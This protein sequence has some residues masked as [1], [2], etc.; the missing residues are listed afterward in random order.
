MSRNSKDSLTGLSRALRKNMTPEEKRI[1][2]GFLKHIP[3]TVNRQKTIDNFIVDF[4]C[5]ELKLVIDTPEAK[6][7]L[8]SFMEE[9][10]HVAVLVDKEIKHIDKASM[11]RLMQKHV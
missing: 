9:E 10:P 6:A 11:D 8:V 5:A 3:F 2:Y 4:Y 7:N 1:W